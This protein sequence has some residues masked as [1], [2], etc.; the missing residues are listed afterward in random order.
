LVT[1]RTRVALRW[2]DLDNLG[3]LNQATYHEFME[4]GR[5]T[6]LHGMPDF[7]FVLARVEM[8]FRHEIRR[9]HDGVDVVMRVGALGRT[10]VTVDHEVRLVDGTVAADGRTILVAWD[11]EQRRPRPLTDAERAAFTGD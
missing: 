1:S 2:R 9:E 7:R 6:L 5:A 8:N 4:E 11:E 10:S 3:H